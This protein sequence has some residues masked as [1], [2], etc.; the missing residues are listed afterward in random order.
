MRRGAT[1]LSLAAA[2]TLVAALASAELDDTWAAGEVRYHA[3][4]QRSAWIGVAPLEIERLAVHVDEL[5]AIDLRAVELVAIVRVAEFRS[6]NALR[7]LHARRSVFDADAHPEARFVL[8]RIEAPESAEAR[9]DGARTLHL[10]GDLTLRGTTREVVVST[11]LALGEGTAEVTATFDVSLEA[12]DLPAPRFLTW[13]VD[14][15]VRVEVDA[16]WPLGPG[17]TATTRPPAPPA[18]GAAATPPAASDARR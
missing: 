8:R 13:V 10:V 3:S 4:D 17:S 5:G 18:P 2:L 11:R 9:T 12:F 1:L 15:H 16:T 14:D 6:G 7:D